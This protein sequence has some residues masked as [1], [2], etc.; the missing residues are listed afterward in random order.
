MRTLLRAAPLI[1]C[2]TVPTASAEVLSVKNVT[3]DFRLFVTVWQG[4]IDVQP[5]A[6]DTVTVEV[7]CRNADDAPPTTNERGLRIIS[8]DQSMPELRKSDDR[9]TFVAAKEAGQCQ[10]SV[11]APA[12]VE[13]RVRVNNKGKITVSKWRAM[14][15]AWSAVGNVI[16]RDQQGPFSVTA[17][18]GD[19]TIEY[20]GETLQADSA[21]TAAN[22]IVALSLAGEPSLTLRTQARWGE[23]ATDLDAAF[24]REQIDDASWSVARLEGG[25]PAVTL[26][27]LNSDIVITRGE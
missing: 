10:F 18:S 4:E 15:T 16:L 11:Y 12:S 6:D 22:G 1:V 5:S 17:M 27:N 3:S 23:V 14:V 21:A 25:G 7:D 2:L 20:R 13:T 8:S 24:S 19:A 26:R 9:V